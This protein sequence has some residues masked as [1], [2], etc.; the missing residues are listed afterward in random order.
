VHSADNTKIFF[1]V[2]SPRG[3]V[4]FALMSHDGTQRNL[5]FLG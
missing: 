2:L 3:R 5:A 4:P 1:M